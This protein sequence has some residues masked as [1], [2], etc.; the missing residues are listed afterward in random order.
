MWLYVAVT[1]N[2]SSEKVKFYRNGHYFSH[3]DEKTS[4]ESA[5]DS[6][7]FYIGARPNNHLTSTNPG[8][9]ACVQLY[10]T[11]LTLSQMK[12]AIIDCKNI[13]DPLQG[14]CN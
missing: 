8:K 9:L 2:A 11:V 14:L 10:D 13:S 6:S 5:T 12:K 3:F 7:Y 4:Y 1:Y